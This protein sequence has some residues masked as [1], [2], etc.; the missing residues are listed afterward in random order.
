[1]HKDPSANTHVHTH[2]NTHTHMV[3][4][5]LLGLCL[6]GLPCGSAV[7][8]PAAVQEMQDTGVQSLGL[9]DPLEEG[10]TIYS[11][12]LAWKIL[13]IEE[14]GYGPWVHRVETTEETEYACM[15]LVILLEIARC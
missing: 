11:N 12:I 1:M 13:W 7:K 8:N 15:Y 2:T 6:V 9:E 5:Y 3:G 4:V 10:M 14:P